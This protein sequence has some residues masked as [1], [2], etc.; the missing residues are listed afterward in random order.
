[1]GE[2]IPVLKYFFNPKNGVVRLIPISCLHVGH[3]NFNVERGKGFI[4]YILKTE[5]TYALML[6][7]T[8]EN[9]LP[10]TAARHKG[11]IH[12]QTM[13]VE[14]QRDVAISLLKPLADAKKI[15]CWNE[16]NHSLRSWYEAG[17]SVER[18][19]A[20]KLNVPFAGTDAL[21]NINVGKQAYSIHVTHG[22]GGGTTLQAVLTRLFAQASRVISADAYI[23]GHHHKKIIGEVCNID[24]RSGA[25]KKRIL[26]ATG[27]FMDY[28][29]GYGHRNELPPVVP[30]CVKIKLYSKKWDIHATL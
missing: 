15:L 9:V 27:C 8:C 4:D 2:K 21:L 23:R 10:E 24:A 26:C 11:S 30:G 20:E 25:I 19:L 12:E 7:D 3:K 16:S 28:V 6:G 5:S 22:T 14:K 17:F 1:M 13:S 18:H 29:D